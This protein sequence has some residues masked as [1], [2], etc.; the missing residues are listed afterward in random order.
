MMR[1]FSLLAVGIAVW[2][3]PAESAVAQLVTPPPPTYS[4]HFKAGPYMQPASSNTRYQLTV[5][6]VTMGPGGSTTQDIMSTTGIPNST[7]SRV[8]L[9]R[10]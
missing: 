1:F 7:W 3:I 10:R 6:I 2:V 8:S 9:C 4:V 5:R